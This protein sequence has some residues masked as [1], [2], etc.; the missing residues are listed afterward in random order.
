MIVV[1]GATGKLGTFVVEGL[2]NQVPVEQ[3]AVVARDAA[4]AARFG[5]LGVEVRVA[6]YNDPASLTDAFREGDKVLL[7]S[8]SEVGQRVP[9]HKAV[10]DAAKNAGVALLAYT[11]VLGG[12][13]ADFELARE[14][15]IT[16]RYLIDS[17]L[18]YTLL[19]NGWYHENYTEGLPG[20]LAAGA[21][22]TST[23]EGAAVA[24]ASRAD[25]AAAAVA[26]L[27]GVGHEGREYELDGDTAWTFDEFAAEVA[28]QSGTDFTVNRISG[29]ELRGILGGQGVPET[30]APILVGVDEAISRGLLVNGSGDL[31]RLAGRPTTP[32]SEAIAKGLK[33]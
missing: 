30:I 15:Q 19:R 6:D 13:A 27:T 12:P 29:E 5:E 21:I 31:S 1:T 11:S 23:T 9:Q 4:K 20:V 24:S 7:I 10:I 26:V 25:Y 16:E 8:G 28:K 3:I 18:P 22:T 33:A 17:G 14:H 32:V 2:I